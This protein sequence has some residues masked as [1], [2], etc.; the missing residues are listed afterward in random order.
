LVN[1][2]L[3]QILALVF[4]SLSLSLAQAKPVERIV[5]LAPHLAE[6]AYSAGVGEK[7]VGVVAFSDYPPPVKQLPIV[8]NYNAIHYEAI[9]RLKPDLIL[10]WQGGNRLQDIERLKQLGFNV[11]AS[12][13]ENLEDIPKEI[14][15]LGE[16]AGNPST[17]RKTADR[18]RQLLQQLKSRH[19]NARPVTAF[20]EIWHQPLMTVNGRS[21]I[22]QALAV[23]K[24]QNIFADLKPIAGQVSV[25]AVLQRNPDVILLGG[26]AKLQPEW[27]RAW[28][29]YPSL[30]A[31]KQNHIFSLNADHF[32]RPT[33]RLI[34]A[35]PGL[36]QKI[37]AVRL[38][39]FK[40]SATKRRNPL[41]VQK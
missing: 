22:S 10:V 15:R 32:Q 12:H 29:A 1:S 30:K 18:L 27:K 14:E 38:E 9:L 7:L 34:Q 16:A 25:E 19:Q 39:A 13:P 4:F 31:V 11:F 21:F 35:L 28:Q 2:K 3:T 6:M 8:G 37:D 33:A 24:A 40:S 36:C 23:C 20:Y 41:T 26:D 5:A 17:A